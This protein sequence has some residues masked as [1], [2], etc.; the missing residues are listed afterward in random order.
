MSS[1][2]ERVAVA[3][4]NI[5]SNKDNIADLYKKHEQLSDIFHKSNMEYRELNVNVK[6]MT[7][8]LNSFIS[9]MKEDRKNMYDKID[10][11]ESK[12]SKNLEELID[13]KISD[14][15]GNTAKTILGWIVKNIG[16]I[17]IVVLTAYIL[18]NLGLK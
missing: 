13:E 16:G 14:K 5:E 17:A 10:S 2:E 4:S 15:D 6:T 8:S 11:Q 18:L 1:I 12:M 7:N 9:E 3:E